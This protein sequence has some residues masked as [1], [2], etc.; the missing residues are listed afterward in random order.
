[1]LFRLRAG[2]VKIVRQKDCDIL[3]GDPLSLR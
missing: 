3:Y 2:K 1:M